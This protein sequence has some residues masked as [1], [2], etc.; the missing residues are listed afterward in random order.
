MLFTE[1]RRTATALTSPAGGRDR[2]NGDVPLYR[3]P[4]VLVDY[5][6]RS[7]AAQPPQK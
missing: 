5:G 1:Q 4:P 3:K 6:L 7:H 2:K